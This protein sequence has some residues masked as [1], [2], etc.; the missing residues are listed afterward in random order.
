MLL[1]LYVAVTEYYLSWDKSVWYR[2]INAVAF[3]CDMNTHSL[4][5]HSPIDGH[6]VFFL[7][8]T[9]AN[10]IV[11][12]LYVSPNAHTEVLWAADLKMELLAHGDLVL[13]L[14]FFTVF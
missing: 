2:H 9:I 12:P 11:L 14:L 8:C 7:V 1:F 6:L 10:N 5:L 3:Y 4:F 13:S